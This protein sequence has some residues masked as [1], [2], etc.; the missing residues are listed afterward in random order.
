MRYSPSDYARA[1]VS[2]IKDAPANEEKI[3]GSFIDLV[4]KNHDFS[5][6]NKIIAEVE[7]LLLE[8]AGVEKV[9]VESARPLTKNKIKEITDRLSQ[10]VEVET[11][12]R[13]ELIA[14]VRVK[15]GDSLSLDAT[16]SRKLRGIFK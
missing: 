15:V 9:V 4:K 1:L 6:L 10:K 14:G 16:L 11:V 3:L 5:Q 8:E 2:A 7:K 12:I 13:P